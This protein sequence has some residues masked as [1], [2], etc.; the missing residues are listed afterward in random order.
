MK[1]AVQLTVQHCRV[2][3]H[4][5]SQTIPSTGIRSG[6]CNSSSSSGGG[7]SGRDIASQWEYGTFKY[8]VFGFNNSTIGVARRPHTSSR[9]DSLACCFLPIYLPRVYAPTPATAEEKQGVDRD[10]AA[11]EAAR[12]QLSGILGNLT[13]EQVVLTATNELTQ[14]QKRVLTASFPRWRLGCRRCQLS[15]APKGSRGY[16]VI[17]AIMPR[18]T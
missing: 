9:H 4:L 1:A 17:R 14:P 8:G 10:V 3:S 18:L 6:S 7:G 12:R 16:D 2:S 13:S 15:L 5:L 11:A